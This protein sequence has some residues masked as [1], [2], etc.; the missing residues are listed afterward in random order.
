M[1]KHFNANILLFIITI[2]WGCSFIL[3]KNES[4]NIEVF[5]FLFL[6]FSIAFVISGTVFYK[7]IIGIDKKT[8]NNS[9]KLSLLLFPAFFLMIMGIKLTTASNAG[10]IQGL[11]VVIIPIIMS[12]FFKENLDRKMIISIFISLIGISVLTI[13]DNMSFNLGDIICLFSVIFFSLHLIYT[14]KVINDSEPISLGIIQ[15]AFISIF[16]LIISILIENPVLPHSSSSWISILLLSVLCT[17]I[18]YIIQTVVQKYTTPTH[19]GLI[20]SFEPISA[21]VFA[22][23][24]SGE[25]LSMQGYIGALILLSGIF[26]SVIKINT[27]IKESF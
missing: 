25:V 5:N 9:F 21:A 26:I 11:G 14:N 4:N 13:K 3:I 20:L 10:F 23:I 8:L 1:N 19:T 15:F 17:A 12:I 7:N 18:T 16:S 22:Y 27:N 6:R 24:I 2:I